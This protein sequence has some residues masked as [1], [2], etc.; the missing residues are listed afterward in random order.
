M[1]AYFFCVFY[2]LLATSFSLTVGHTSIEGH[3][4]LF[5][6]LLRRLRRFRFTYLSHKK[7][8]FVF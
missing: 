6:R 2:A 4:V 5:V 8:S 7:F 3:V 1:L